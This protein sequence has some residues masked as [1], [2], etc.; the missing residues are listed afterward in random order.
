MSTIADLV[1][2]EVDPEMEIS[3]QEVYKGVLVGLNLRK[4]K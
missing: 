3:L 1:P 2:G 4:G